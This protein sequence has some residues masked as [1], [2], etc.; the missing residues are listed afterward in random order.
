MC[1]D[2]SWLWVQALRDCP[3]QPPRPLSSTLRAHLEEAAARCRPAAGQP[4]PFCRI[5]VRRVRKWCL[6]HLQAGGWATGGEVVDAGMQALCELSVDTEVLRRQLQQSI[7]L[8]EREGLLTCRKANG[9]LC[10]KT[11]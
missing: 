7:R 10:V 6:W 9:K 4:H 1:P 5:R 8:L 11:S 3:L 2:W